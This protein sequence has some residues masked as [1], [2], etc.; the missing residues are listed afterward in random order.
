MNR[1]LTV[2]G[3]L[4]IGALGGIYVDRHFKDQRQAAFKAD[5]DAYYAAYPMDCREEG[6]YTICKSRQWTME[7]GR[8]VPVAD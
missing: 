6:K 8:F 2:F 3:L 4:T 7:S 5:M 1:V